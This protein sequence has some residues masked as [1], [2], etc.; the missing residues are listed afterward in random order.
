MINCKVHKKSNSVYVKEL[1]AKI[2][3]MILQVALEKKFG[4]DLRY[5]L[6]KNTVKA[7]KNI[8]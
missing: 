8:S 7:I 4:I 1:K 2:K 6:G 5:L 3:K